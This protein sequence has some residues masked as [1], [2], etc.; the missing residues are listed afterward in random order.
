M[1]LS[2]FKST[3]DFIC[4]PMLDFVVANLVHEL[5]MLQIDNDVDW[6]WQQTCTST[7]SSVVEDLV[8]VSALLAQY[9]CTSQGTTDPVNFQLICFCYC[10]ILPDVCQLF[11][12]YP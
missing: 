8:N 5:W 3:D 6:T 9:L 1:S 7:A 2:S 12:S 10:P 4:E 11:S